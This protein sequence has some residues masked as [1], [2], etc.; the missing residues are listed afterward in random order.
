MV[1]MI[2]LQ[3]ALDQTTDI[4]LNKLIEIVNESVYANSP[5]WYTRSF[6]FRDSWQKKPITTIGMRCQSEIYQ[7]I[8]TMVWDA[9]MFQHGN[10]Y[11]PLDGSALSDILNNGTN[12]AGFG[13]SPVVATEFWDTFMTW[14]NANVDRIFATNCYAN[15]LVLRGGLI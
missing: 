10:I 5:E 1:L 13:F 8:S 11:E 14:A 9:Q 4:L 2:P 6:E 7:D 15:G 12:N 3:K